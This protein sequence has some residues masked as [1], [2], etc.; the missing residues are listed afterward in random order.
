VLQRDAPVLI[1][2]L[3]P[4]CVAVQMVSERPASRWQRLWQRVAAGVRPGRLQS[5]AG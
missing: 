5:A 3:D 4:A 1:Q 2:A